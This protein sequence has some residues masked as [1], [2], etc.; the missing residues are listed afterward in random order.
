MPFACGLGGHIALEPEWRPQIMKIKFP[1]T[2][3][4]ARAAE[5][6]RVGFT[7]PVGDEII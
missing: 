2:L 7:A 4:A 1:Q 5:P 6:I 3:E